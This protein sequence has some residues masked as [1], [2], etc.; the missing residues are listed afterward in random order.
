MRYRIKQSGRHE[1]SRA[2]S[3]AYLI[4]EIEIFFRLNRDDVVKEISFAIGPGPHPVAELF[5]GAQDVETRRGRYLV[6]H[7]EDGGPFDGVDPALE[8]KK[9]GIVL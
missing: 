5:L 7:P 3:D 6:K 4:Q 8:E 1:L 9:N 2:H